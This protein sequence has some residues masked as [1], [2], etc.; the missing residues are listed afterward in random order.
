MNI[1]VLNACSNTIVRPDTTLKKNSDDLYVPEFVNSISWSPVFFV[2]ISKPG[3]YIAPRFVERHYDS[4][5][6]GILLYPEDFIDGNEEGYAMASCMDHTSFLPF[7]MYNK[8]LLGNPNNKVEFLKNGNSIFSSDF[9]P[10][11]CVET[12]LEKVSKICY[13][14]TGD[15]ACMELQQRQKLCSREEGEICHVSGTCCGNYLMD[16]KIIF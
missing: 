13:L 14:R 2:R 10:V 7:P 9:A 8:S 16:F 5:N 4:V 15:L 1:V 3:K 11:E 6:Y 12:I